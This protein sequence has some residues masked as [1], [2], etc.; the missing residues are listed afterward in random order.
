[1]L[2]T[3]IGCE[4]N[5]HPLNQRYNAPLDASGIALGSMRCCDDGPDEP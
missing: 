4:G 1:M 5:T 3:R 2:L